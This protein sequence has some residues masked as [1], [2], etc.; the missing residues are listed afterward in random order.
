MPSGITVR[1]AIGGA[2]KRLGYKISDFGLELSLSGNTG[3][4]DIQ[5][6][7]LWLVWK[8]KTIAREG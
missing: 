8:G 5:R 4:Y 3:G 7:G 2:L 1:K 6:F